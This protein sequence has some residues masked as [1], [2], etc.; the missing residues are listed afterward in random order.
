MWV[1]FSAA[2]RLRDDLDQ[3][4][5]KILG[6]SG[7]QKHTE[8]QEPQT[9]EELLEAALNAKVDTNAILNEAPEQEK[10]DQVENKQTEDDS[11]NLSQE[12]PQK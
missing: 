7:T 12:A 11:Q 10:Q 1:A 6:G 4:M 3:A 8:L 9:E 5:D 2:I